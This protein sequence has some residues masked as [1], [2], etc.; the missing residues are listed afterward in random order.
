ML[1]LTE[2]FDEVLGADCHHAVV[3]E[4]ELVFAALGLALQQSVT[5]QHIAAFAA[6]RRGPG[7]QDIFAALAEIG[8]RYRV[9]VEEVIE[10]TTASVVA[11]GENIIA[12]ASNSGHG[13]RVT[14]ENIIK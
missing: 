9:A 5:P 1:A 3:F 10:Q 8:Q 14:A 6:G 11:S 2:V 4:H 13:I 12:A 7:I